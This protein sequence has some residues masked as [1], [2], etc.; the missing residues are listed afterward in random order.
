MGIAGVLTGPQ[1]MILSAL[2]P[3]CGLKQVPTPSCRIILVLYGVARV[4]I[5][6]P[7]PSLVFPPQ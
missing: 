3:A 5:I 1:W 7:V 6:H 2:A 4:H